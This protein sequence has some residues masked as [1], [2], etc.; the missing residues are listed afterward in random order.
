M[1]RFSSFVQLYQD[2]ALDKSKIHDFYK[3]ISERLGLDQF[4]DLCHKKF[5]QQ[6]SVEWGVSRLLA[7]F[8]KVSEVELSNSVKCDGGEWSFMDVSVENLLPLHVNSNSISIE[9]MMSDYELPESVDG[10]VNRLERCDI[11]SGV[12]FTNYTKRVDLTIK[13]PLLVLSINR[14]TEIWDGTKVVRKKLLIPISITEDGV[15]DEEDQPLSSFGGRQLVG[16]IKHI[17]GAGSGHYVA[18]VRSGPHWFL[19]N[20]NT[21]TKQKT[22]FWETKSFQSNIVCLVY[23][24]SPNSLAPIGIHNFGNTCFMAAALQVLL[25]SP[26]FMKKIGDDEKKDSMHDYES[27]DIQE[28]YT[29][30]DDYNSEEDNYDIRVLQT[31]LSDE[32]DFDR[33]SISELRNMAKSIGVKTDLD[34]HRLIQ[35]LDNAWA[36]GS[37]IWKSGMEARLQDLLS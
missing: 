30:D 23:D 24:G 6:D 8:P 25:H 2:K 21:V 14:N 22:K 26:S 36:N 35:I 18:Y 13:G 9:Q 16:A 33:M 28:N 1:D 32:P 34:K 17:G 29:G 11:D 4:G 15:E 10:R 27:F 31:W 3:F 37:S 19:C 20:D 7:E 5:P 12:R